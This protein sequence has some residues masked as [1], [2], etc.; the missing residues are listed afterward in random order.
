RGFIGP[1]AWVDITQDGSPDIVANA[2]DGRVLA[3]DG[4]TYKPL[5][6]TQVA[7]TEAYTT[8]GIGYFTD[9]DIPDFFV[10]FAQGRYPYLTTT[11]QAMLDGRS[12]AI[13]YLDSLGHYQT[14]SPV[15]ADIN[16][17]GRDE[18]LL[19]V[20]EEVIE[21]RRKAFHTNL[22]N[23]DFTTNKVFRFV[24]ALPG[25]NLATTPW[26]GDMDDDGYL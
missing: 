19:S 1:P 12:G 22:L 2:V 20:D 8:V 14:S 21:D 23:I 9:D 16:G 24:P 6:S 18:V 4:T 25:H 10:S 13:R 26:V 3:F 7:K 5:W 11:K 15:V 17:D